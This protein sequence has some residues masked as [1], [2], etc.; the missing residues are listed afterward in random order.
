V[1]EVQSG[2]S[3]P[4]VIPLMIQGGVQTSQYVE[5]AGTAATGALEI[6]SQPAGARILIDGQSRGTS[7]AT[8]RD[9]SPGDHTVVLELRGRKVSQTVKI[10]AGSTSKLSVPIK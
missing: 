8:I 5:L 9:L 6:V 7:P 4:R 2:K 3:E 10:Q 1:L